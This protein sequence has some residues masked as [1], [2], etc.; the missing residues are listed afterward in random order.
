MKHAIPMFLLSI[1]HFCC[2]AVLF[3]RTTQVVDEE[4]L[5]EELVSKMRRRRRQGAVDEEIAKI[6][7]ERL[8]VNARL[9]ALRSVKLAELKGT[10]GGD[11]EAADQGERFSLTET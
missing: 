6:E 11:T 3:V 5:L 8:E 7:D 4:D 2:S 1:S 9:T 10:M